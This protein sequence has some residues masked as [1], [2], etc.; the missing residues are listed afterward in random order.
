MEIES[1]RPFDWV[2]SHEFK[3]DPKCPHCGHE[4]TGWWEWSL[5]EDEEEE[6]ECEHCDQPFIVRMFVP[7]PTFDTRK[8]DAEKKYYDIGDKT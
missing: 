2:W 3:D 5:A 6:R 4:D 7:Q 1:G 8:V